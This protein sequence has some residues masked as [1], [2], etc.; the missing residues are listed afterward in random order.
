MGSVTD[1][2]GINI[3]LINYLGI[4]CQRRKSILI[5]EVIQLNLFKHI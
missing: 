5:S 2:C 4:H 1:P 3:D